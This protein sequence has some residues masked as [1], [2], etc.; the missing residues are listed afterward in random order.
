MRNVFEIHSVNLI[1][2]CIL[3]LGLAYSKKG[4][5][6]AEHER[7]LNGLVIALVGMYVLVLYICRILQKNS[8]CEG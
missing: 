4:E 6:D 2:L 8:G 3:L 7:V 1:I 5:N